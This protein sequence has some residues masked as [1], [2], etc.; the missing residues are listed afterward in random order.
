[1]V[2][3]AK[4]TVF[5]AALAK[6]EAPVRT[7]AMPAEAKTFVACDGVESFKGTSFQ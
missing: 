3:I 2:G 7:T 4:V 5:V 6:K 1:M